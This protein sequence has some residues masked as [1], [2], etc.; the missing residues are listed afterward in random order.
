MGA[1]QLELN[2][3]KEWLHP[4]YLEPTAKE[5]PG[6]GEAGRM[7]LS[8]CHPQQTGWLIG[9]SFARVF[10]QG[11]INAIGEFLSEPAVADRCFCYQGC[12]QGIW[13]NAL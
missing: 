4:R 11:R 7:F 8:Q 9:H 6:E 10:L 1:L 2:Y 12:Y 5:A 13:L 3:T